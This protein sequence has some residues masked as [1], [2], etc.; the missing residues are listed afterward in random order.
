M[1]ACGVMTFVNDVTSCYDVMLCLNTTYN[2]ISLN[3]N[4][5]DLRCKF[6]RGVMTS[7]NDVTICHDVTL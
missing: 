2:E 4:N 5:N 7:R 3:I 1:F 6:A